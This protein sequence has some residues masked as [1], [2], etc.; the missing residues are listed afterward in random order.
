M[1]LLGAQSFV[2]R[3]FSVVRILL[4]SRQKMIRGRKQY[5][6]LKGKKQ[7]TYQYEISQFTM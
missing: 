5:L 7:L 1:S 2:F 3:T 6:K 4:F